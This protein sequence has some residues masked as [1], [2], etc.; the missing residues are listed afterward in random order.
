MAAQR[1]TWR[2]W[3]PAGVAEPP[4]DD[5]LTREQVIAVLGRRRVKVTET[6]LR[7][8]E[9]EGVLPHPVRQWH[10]TAVRALYPPWYP[11]LVRRIR[12]LQRDGYPLAAIARELRSQVR[13]FGTV[14][15]QRDAL[16]APAP[17]ASDLE[18]FIAEY[19]RVTGESVT[20]VS[21]VVETAEKSWTNYPVWV[22]ATE[23]DETPDAPSSLPTESE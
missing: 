6:A 13:A 2:D 23:S 8:W 11:D 21:L 4:V 18:R 14:T 20:R 10:G 9:R 3:L 5:L 1:E 17:P 19:A 16:M 15:R 12:R 7:S 22:L